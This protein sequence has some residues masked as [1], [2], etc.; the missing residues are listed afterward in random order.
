[1]EGGGVPF[2]VLAAVPG[3]GKTTFAVKLLWEHIGLLKD[4]NDNST[5]QGSDH[6]MLSGRWQ[7]SDHAMLTDEKET[8]PERGGGGARDDDR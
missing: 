5:L 2:V 8:A 3:A 1:M 4:L 7:L 6:A